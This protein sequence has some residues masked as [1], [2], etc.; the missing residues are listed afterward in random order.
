MILAAMD[1]ALMF[2]VF[3]GI[4]FSIAGLWFA[5]SF[6]RNAIH[7]PA[8]KARRKYI[9]GALVSMFALCFIVYIPYR[10]YHLLTDYVWVNGK[11]IGRCKGR[12]SL[13][14]YEFEY[15][16]DGKRY[17]ECSN[18]GGVQN[19]KSPGGIYRV[20]V[21]RAVPASGRIDFRREVRN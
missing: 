7:P 15:Y 6:T 3:L 16:L 2:G 12:G 1:G 10:E 14:H 9:V 4:L 18:S 11:V 21:S 17:T 13:I 5:I 20:R 8:N 19:I